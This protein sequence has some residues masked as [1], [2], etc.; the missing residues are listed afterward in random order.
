MAGGKVEYRK[1]EL[2]VLGSISEHTFTNTG[3][4]GGLGPQGKNRNNPDF[5]LDKF[6]EPS[7]S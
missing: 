4:V 5:Q 7:H 6:N 3:I 1:P 2:K